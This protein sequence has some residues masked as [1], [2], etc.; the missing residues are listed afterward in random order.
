MP[1][2]AD[3]SMDLTRTLL[4][5]LFIGAL[6]V[7]TFW[8]LFPFLGALLWA[9]M[10]VISTW[11]L[12]VRLRA[13]LWERRALA[14]AVMTLGLLLV[15]VVPLAVSVGAL[16]ANSDKI[17]AWATSLNKAGLPPPPKWV[18]GIPL[19]GPKLSAAWD[20]LVVAGPEGVRSRALPF[21]GRFMQWFAGRVGEIGGM[22]L[23]FLLTVILSAVLYANGEAAGRGVCNFAYRLAGHRGEKAAL[24]A[25]SSVRGVAMGVVLTA[26][27]QTLIAGIGL[28][29]ASVPAALLLTGAMLIL[30]LAQLGP[31]PVMVPVVV[32]KFYTGDALWGGI[33]LAFTLVATTIDN[34][35]RPVLIRKGA[36]LPLLLIFA[37]VI[38]GMISLGVMGIFV[39]PAV[40]GVTYVLVA[41]WVGKRDEA[42]EKAASSG[43]VAGAPGV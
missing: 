7:G 9:T 43:A 10:I 26:V 36:D 37:G 18:A 29:I 4:A 15:L 34:F 5:V 1:Q 21:A 30:C 35:L 12:F 11:P 20:E 38:G 27:I 17:A 3:S 8:I 32:W 14:T 28:V 42:Q 23:Q 31:V 13:R 6:I 25:A 39:G 24:L 19:A 22:I 33:L 2:N 40:L 16:A 41:E